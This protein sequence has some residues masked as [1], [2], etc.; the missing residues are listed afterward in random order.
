M[1]VGVSVALVVS[2]VD[3]AV[4]VDVTVEVGVLVA[5]SSETTIKTKTDCPKAAPLAVDTRQ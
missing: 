3:V 2:G 5:A 4:K 1:K